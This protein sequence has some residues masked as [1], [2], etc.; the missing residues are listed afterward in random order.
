MKN[1]RF[2]LPGAAPATDR[3]IVF[4]HIRNQAIVGQLA[5]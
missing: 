2:I 1:R 4:P 3:A 5:V